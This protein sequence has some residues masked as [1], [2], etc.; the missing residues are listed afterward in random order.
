MGG[1]GKNAESW[2]CIE[3]YSRGVKSTG[4]MEYQ[5]SSTNKLKKYPD[6][7]STSITIRPKRVQLYK[8]S[9]STFI[10]GGA[11]TLIE[12]DHFKKSVE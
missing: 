2:P 6:H 3:N 1:K 11:G 7:K 12:T 9:K 5:N 4:R 8:T 10:Q